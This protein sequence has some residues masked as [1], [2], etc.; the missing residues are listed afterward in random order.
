MERADKVVFQTYGR[1]P[2]VLARG[3]GCRV[4]DDE[5]RV[6]L[7]LV[8]G[9][10]VCNVG[11]CH[12]K[13]VRAIQGQA[14]RLIHTSNLYYTQP[15]V[16]LAE[17]LVALTFA[18]RVFFC[19]SGAEANEG[20]LKLARKVAK[21]RG[22]PERYEVITME[23]SFHG[24]SLATLTATGQE[25]YHHGFEPLVPGFPHVP[26]GDLEAARAAVGERTC[27]ILVEPIQGEGGVK[28]PPAGYL[29]GLRELCDEKGIL[30]I[31]DEVQTGVGRTGEL[32]AHQ[33]AGMTPHAM[34]VAKGIAGGLP[35]GALLATEDVAASLTPGSH[36]STFGGNPVAAAAAMATLS[37]LV[38][39]GLLEAMV[40]VARRFREGLEGMARSYPQV[41]EVRGRGLMLGMELKEPGRP[42][43]EACMRRRLLVNCT[44]DRVLRFVPPLVLSLDEAEEALGVLADAFKEIFG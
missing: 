8:A 28:C 10:A 16:E 25:K 22:H 29:K 36:A 42:I 13:V 35:M 2:I 3:D 31:L 37:I 24:R 33:G 34:T 18:D 38:D 15:M 30:L 26:F 7:D 9:L 11:H 14:E 27:A 4:W 17:R 5:G 41:V 40:P 43:V 19:N 12:P 21:D 6:Y 1:S 44:M 20:A 32:F 23:G 39:D